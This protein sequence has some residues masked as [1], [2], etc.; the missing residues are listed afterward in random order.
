MASFESTPRSRGPGSVSLGEQVRTFWGRVTDGLE[1][2]ELWGQ[3]KADARA[4][5]GWYSKEIDWEPVE[6]ESRRKR[7]WRTAKALFWAMVMKLS[8][9]RRVLLIVALALVIL[10]ILGTEVRVSDTTVISLGGGEAILGALTL[11]LL[12]ALELA[13]RVTMKRDLEI[14]K[15]IQRWL[16]PET[17][18]VIPGVEIAFASRAANTVAGDYYDAFLRSGSADP[19]APPA[20]QN[21]GGADSG[22]LLLVVADVAGKSVPAALLMATFQASLRTLSLYPGPITEL[23]RGLNAYACEHS[24][25]GRRF[26]T[27]FLAELDLATRRLTY[28]NAGHNEPMLLRAPASP[29]GLERL[30][31]GGPPLGIMRNARYECGEVTLAPRDRLVIFTDGVVEAE[32]QAAA[33]FEEG[34]LLTELQLGRSSSA[35]DALKRLMASIDTFVGHAPQHDDITCLILDCC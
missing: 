26:T 35:A 5:Y 30:G 19:G 28:V 23:V 10:G 29:G 8:P 34:R 24:Q 31:Q 17:P 18:P 14:A 27:A 6:G 3:F 22:R 16:V 11:L 20:T 7:Y 4:G 25:S 15:E 12:L 21:L 1:I 13:D 2:Q 32:N 9:A 33:E